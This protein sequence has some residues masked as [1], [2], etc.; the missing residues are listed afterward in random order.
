M[1]NVSG[2]LT[3]KVIFSVLFLFDSLS[4][5]GQNKDRWN[6]GSAKQLT[7]NITSLVCFIS[8]K[9]NIWLAQ[10]KEKILSEITETE[11]WFQNQ[12]GKYN[13]DIIFN[14]DFLD[15]STDIIFDTIEPGLASG[16]ERVDWVYRIIQKSRYTNLKRATKKFKAKY[17][18][19]NLHVLIFAKGRGRSYSMRYA[20]GM[21]KKK[22]YLEGTLIYN[23]YLNGSP[24]PMQSIIA[25]ELLHIYG[26]WDLYSTY[27]QTPDRQLKA[28]ELYP[29][30]IML[31]VDHN[32]TSLKI[33]ELTA[34]L[35]GWNNKFDSSF[36]WF[37]PSDY[38]K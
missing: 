32:I 8:T 29:N 23:E 34:W 21:N 30:D 24:A 33:N 37:R 10:E 3:L 16:E 14:H 35:I 1:K 25:H 17:N 11:R 31:R 7:G 36:E 27:A 28:Q 26:A 13:I 15:S 5:I 6:A 12:A 18:S 20:K 4:T 22:Y 19:D 38:K 2:T 9:D